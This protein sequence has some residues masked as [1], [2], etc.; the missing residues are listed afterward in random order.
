[1]KGRLAVGSD[2]QSQAKGH[3]GQALTDVATSTSTRAAQDSSSP[4]VQAFDAQR[5]EESL[6]VFRLRPLRCFC[7]IQAPDWSITPWE[8]RCSLKW[9]ATGSSVRNSSLSF[10]STPSFL[11]L[12]LKPPI[13]LVFSL[14]LTNLPQ[15][16]IS[17]SFRAFSVTQYAL[18]LASH[19]HPIHRPRPR[20]YH[21]R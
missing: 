6:S 1:M 10:S 9:R 5:S 3:V 7:K 14:L 21:L 18:E 13:P 19:V 12:L 17:S 15:L 8:H 2:N 4:R 16:L 20:F 11:C